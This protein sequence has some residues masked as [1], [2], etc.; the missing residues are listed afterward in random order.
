MHELTKQALTTW[1]ADETQ[2]LAVAS[3]LVGLDCL[4]QQ[5]KTLAKAVHKR[6]HHTPSY[7][8]WRTVQGMGTILAQTITLET[9]ALSR[10]PTVGHSASHCRGV[11]SMK[12][13]NGK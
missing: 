3:S 13:S 1:L 10:V 8:Q 12:L 6:L 11:D 7:E 5:I 9:G 4:R 2:V